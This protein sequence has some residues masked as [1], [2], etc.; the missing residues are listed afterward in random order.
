MHKHFA[1]AAALSLL[2]ALAPAFAGGATYGKNLIRNPGA[3]AGAGSED[4]NDLLP[5]PKWETSGNFTAVVYGAPDFPAP[6]DPGPKKRGL[7]FFAGGPDAATS[8]ARQAIDVS[9]YAANIDARAVRYAASGWLGGFGSQDDGAALKFVFADAAGAELRS[10]VMDGPTAAERGNVTAL[11]KRSSHGVVP[12]GTRTVLV[13]LT[14]T[15]VAGNYND[16]YADA[17]SFVLAP[18]SGDDQDEDTA[19]AST[20]N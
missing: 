17:L 13:E 19:I 14:M 3:E 15:R 18:A 6:T 2:V 9:A 12:R 1:G 11:M 20:T 16:G 8:S 7:N 4:G 5:I 10:L